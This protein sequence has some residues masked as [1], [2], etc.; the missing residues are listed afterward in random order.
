MFWDVQKLQEEAYPLLP[1]LKFLHC[2]LIKQE[3]LSRQSAGK[4]VRTVLDKNMLEKR[5]FTTRCENKV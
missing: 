2:W 4:G 3:L 5:T 1:R